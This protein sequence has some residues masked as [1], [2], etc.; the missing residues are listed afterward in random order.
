[1]DKKIKVGEIQG[2]E[3]IYIPDRGLLFCKNT[4][5]RYSDIENILKSSNQKEEIPEKNLEIIKDND[6]IH[7]GCLTTTIE[8]CKAIKKEIRK[9]H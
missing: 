6:I 5:V 7:F 1:M 2:H 9:I 8:N 4:I 3:V